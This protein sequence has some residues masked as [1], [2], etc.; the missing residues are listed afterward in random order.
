MSPFPATG[1]AA[2]HPAW[3]SAT[4]VWGSMASHTAKGRGGLGDPSS[5]PGDYALPMDGPASESVS[6]PKVFFAVG[7]ARSGTTLLTRILSAHPRIALHHERRVLELSQRVG[8]ALAPEGTSQEQQDAGR[9]HA[10]RVLRWQAPADAA[11]VGDKYPPYA[12]QIPALD[13]A[14]PGCRVVHIVRDPRGVVASWLS[15]WPR[16]HPWRRGSRVPS[17]PTIA[18]NWR[19]SVRQADEAGRGLGPERYLPVR[20]EDLLADPHGVGRSLLAFLGQVPAPSFSAALDTIGLRGDWR[21]DLSDA[22][23]AAVEAAPGVGAAMDAWGWCPVASADPRPDTAADWAARAEAASDA[24]AARRAWLRVLRLQP[25]HAGASAALMAEPARG[26]ALFGMLH[27]APAAQ[28]V[29][30]AARLAALLR[31]RGLS[32]TAAA[33]VCGLSS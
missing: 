33:A 3:Q 26:E 24:D 22:E 28:S 5:V 19:Q 17:V 12:G 30:A 10:L 13:A 16:S 18:E 20:Y 29:A 15:V 32:P 23:V 8:R 25:G 2:K 7:A 6:A 27:D 11:W 9:P 14:F 1:A 21:R 4:P 31:S